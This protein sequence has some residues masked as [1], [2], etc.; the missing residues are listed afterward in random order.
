MK[1]KLKWSLLVSEMSRG[2]DRDLD[3]FGAGRGPCSEFIPVIIVLG[4]RHIDDFSSRL[5]NL[6][7][8]LDLPVLW[9]AQS[10]RW[11]L[12]QTL[13]NLPVAICKFIMPNCAHWSQKLVK[14]LQS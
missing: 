9:L 11:N 3:L 1:I 4:G 12:G 2:G 6:L 7:L 5:V 10:L 13:E 14:V 8:N